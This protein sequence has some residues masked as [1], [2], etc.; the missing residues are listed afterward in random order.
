MAIVAPGDLT[1]A[2][3][4]DLLVHRG[5]ITAEQRDWAL[6]A[7][8]RTGSPVSVIV[9]ASGLVRRQ[10]LYIVLGDIWHAPYIDLVADPPDPDVLAGLDP[11]Q[12]VRDGWIPV[13]VLPDGTVLAAAPHAPTADLLSS[14]ERT[15][16]RSVTYAVTTDWDIRYALQRAVVD[17]HHPR[18]PWF[19]ADQAEGM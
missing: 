2:E 8:D 4:G 12:L 18:S 7:H 16:G 10:Q 11:G 14:I 19:P 15:T 13:R 17:D 1:Q 5:L 3:I 6:D 9:I